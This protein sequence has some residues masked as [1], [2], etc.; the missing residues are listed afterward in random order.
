[1]EPISEIGSRALEAAADLKDLLHLAHGALH[2]IE[3]D[4]HGKNYV[5]AKELTVKLHNLRRE[6]SIFSMEID[7]YVKEI[8]SDR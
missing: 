3:Q 7:A 5:K 8:E 6:V 2:R 4:I 1:M